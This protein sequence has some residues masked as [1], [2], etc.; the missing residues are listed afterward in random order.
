MTTKHF[1]TGAT[2][3]SGLL[4]LNAPL[5]AAV[6]SD[7]VGYSTIECV[8]GYSAIS[9]PFNPLGKGD[10]EGVAL[11]DIKGNLAQSD[12][13]SR[14]D[15]IMLM[16][17]VTKAY[18]TYQ[19]KEIGWVKA[20]ET[21]PTTDIVTPGM[22]FLFVKGVTDGDFLVCGKVK[23]EP[24][25]TCAL[26]RGYNLIANPYPCAVKI[27]DLKGDL[28]AN[29]RES[30]ADRIMVLNPVTKAYTTYQLRASSGWTKEGETTTTTDQINA[31][32]GFYFIKAVQDGALTF[33]RPY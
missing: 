6:E 13:E 28:S 29:D 9:L 1:L 32:E 8:R 18:S 25:I 11:Q 2:L 21:E 19:Y 15:R 24:S 16:N 5:F 27:A 14:S 22:G 10:V 7:V 3:L 17:P 4:L 33:V 31:C 26:S 23:S 20:G 30:R 12:R